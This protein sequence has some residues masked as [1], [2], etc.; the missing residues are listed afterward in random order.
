MGLSALVQCLRPREV[1]RFRD[2]AVEGLAF[3]SAE[4]RRG[5]VFFAVKGSQLDGGDYVHHALVKGAVAVV[6]EQPLAL[7]V[8]TLVVPNVRAALADAASFYYQHPSRQIPVIGVT[9]TNG[10]TTVV[11]LIRAC[12]E[13]EGWQVGSLGTIAYEFAGRRIPASNTTPDA[14]RIQGY[15]RE[16]ADR[17]LDACAMEVSS[18]ALCQE[19]VRGVDFRVGVF[20]NLSQDHLDYH[21]TL[22]DYTEAKALL[23]R[24]LRP[25][26]HAC[27]ARD[28]P[29]GARM[30]DVLDPGVR[31]T[32][33]G[34]SHDAD[35]RAE[36]LVGTLEGTRFDAVLPNG[37]VRLMLRLIGLHNVRNA[38]AA[39]AAASALG[40]S[41]LT[42]A[43]ALESVPPVRGR[44]ELV[45]NQSGRR[46]YV[47]YA[48]TPDALQN[49]C[50]TLRSLSKGRLFVVFGCGGDRDKSKRPLMA[51]AVAAHADA[52][53]LTSDNPRSEDPEAI[54]DA[55]E[56]GLRDVDGA[57]YRVADR[58]T[59]IQRA[60]QKAGPSDVVLIAGKGHETY[61]ILRDS[62]VPFDDAE[63]AREALREEKWLQ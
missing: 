43:S 49:A 50:A 59:A 12:L 31:T 21:K 37:R 55:M 44:L 15:L 5:N 19:R 36:N 7:T 9:G 26:S 51:R 28:D 29:A 32:T 63:V 57:F 14:L 60:V 53:F 52:A 45:G 13:A 22:R 3:H 2:V 58:R 16:M 56:A 8:P 10:K 11:S 42:I 18:H 48:H 46:V 38:L 40:V 47:D 54:L 39:A 35:I 24:G 27:I 1:L 61:Q 4:V 62:I 33:F 41:D 6:A 25:S 23:F 30:R 34:L 20:L 17:C